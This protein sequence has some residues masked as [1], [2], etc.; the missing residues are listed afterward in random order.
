MSHSDWNH[1]RS[2]KDDFLS[3]DSIAVIWCVED[4]LMR[5]E[6]QGIP[7]TKDEARTILARM[8]HKHDACI[9]I[10]WDVID[11]YIDMHRLDIEY[12]NNK[13]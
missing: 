2:S 13:G 8:D 10:S 7:L 1:I 6:E 5:A 9:G 12:E 4:V 3:G 11:C